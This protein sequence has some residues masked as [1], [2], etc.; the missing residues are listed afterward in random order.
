MVV[1]IVS[2]DSSQVDSVIA[3]MFS[4]LFSVVMETSS[5]QIV[6]MVSVIIDV[7]SVIVGK[8]VDWSCSS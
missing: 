2:N 7:S 5:L 4:L 3:V 6:S 1:S 8:V